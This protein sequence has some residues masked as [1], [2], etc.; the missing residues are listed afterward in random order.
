MVLSLLTLSSYLLWVCLF[1]KYLGECQSVLARVYNEERVSNAPYPYSTCN[2]TWYRDVFEVIVSF[3]PH[4]QAIPA[5]KCRDEVG[6][7]LSSSCCAVSSAPIFRLLRYGG[8]LDIGA[9]VEVNPDDQYQFLSVYT[10][11]NAPFS[12]AWLSHYFPES[13]SYRAMGRS[14][15]SLHYMYSFKRMV[16]QYTK[17]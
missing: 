17:Q 15:L 1:F 11:H 13:I 10:R 9:E 4:P 2:S 5:N 12:V 6:G 8:F 7:Y 3:R 16:L 14:I